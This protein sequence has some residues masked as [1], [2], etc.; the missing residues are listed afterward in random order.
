MPAVIAPIARGGYGRQG[1]VATAGTIT[2]D[3][4]YTEPEVPAALLA[5][6]EAQPGDYILGAMSYTSI[7][8]P[9]TQEPTCT[10]P[11]TMTKLGATLDL[12]G[13]RYAAVFGGFVDRYLDDSSISFTCPVTGNFHMMTVQIYRGVDKTTPIDA[14]T[15]TAVTSSGT[16]HVGPSITPV[17]DGALVVSIMA[18]NNDNGANLSVFSGTPTGCTV[19]IN[20]GSSTGTDGSQRYSS[21]IVSPA[22]AT[23]VTETTSLAVVCGA[24]A[25]ALRPASSSPIDQVFVGRSRIAFTTPTSGALSRT[26]TLPVESQ[27]RLAASSTDVLVVCASDWGTAVNITNL[28]AWTTVRATSPYVYVAPYDAAI[29]FP[30]FSRNPS[31]VRFMAFVLILRDLDLTDID[32]VIA[33]TVAAS[34]GTTIT[35]PDATPTRNDAVV[36]RIGYI[37][38]D[39]PKPNGDLTSGQYIIGNTGSGTGFWWTTN[40][41]D[42]GLLISLDP[43]TGGAG[44]ALGTKTGT[45]SSVSGTHDAQTIVFNRAPRIVQLVSTVQTAAFVVLTTAA[46]ADADPFIDTVVVVGA[47]GVTTTLQ[48]TAPRWSEPRRDHLWVRNLSGQQIGV[49]R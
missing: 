4:I 24:F 34:S 6:F 43:L 1:F 10:G 29:V 18:A 37:G 32:D 14:T 3:G 49:I 28:G 9:S 27:N 5:T 25:V 44:V 36:L 35:Y 11:E 41:S 19:D 39:L 22:A 13:T 45:I 21:K 30:T 15:T 23:S 17:T 46:D 12:G 47:L 33:S 38:D 7:V 31:P 26:P 16:S 40:Q 8:P 2:I 48:S 20:A 42:A